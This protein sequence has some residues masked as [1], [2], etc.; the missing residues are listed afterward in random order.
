M[1]ADVVDHDTKQTIHSLSIVGYGGWWLLKPGDTHFRFCALPIT[2]PL[3]ADKQKEAKQNAV[4]IEPSEQ[5]TI[6]QKHSNT[7]NLKRQPPQTN[8]A[9]SNQ[10]ITSPV[11]TKSNPCSSSTATKKTSAAT[12]NTSN[13]KT[14]AGNTSK[15]NTMHQQ[16]SSSDDSALIILPSE[17][18]GAS[19]K[20]VG[21]LRP[22]SK[23]SGR[24]KRRSVRLRNQRQQEQLVEDIASDET[25]PKLYEEPFAKK[26][27][28]LFLNAPTGKQRDLWPELEEFGYTQ[29]GK[30]I[31]IMDWSKLFVDTSNVPKM[32]IYSKTTDCAEFL[33]SM[34]DC[35]LDLLAFFLNEDTKL[36]PNG[37]LPKVGVW[38][39]EYVQDA[40]AK[41]KTIDSEGNTA[42]KRAAWIRAKVFDIRHY[43]AET[44]QI[45]SVMFASVYQKLHKCNLLYYWDRD[46]QRM[47]TISEHKLSTGSTP[48]TLRK[49][50]E[51]YK[52][53]PKSLNCN[54][55]TL[56]QDSAKGTKAQSSPVRQKAQSDRSSEGSEA[57][58][59]D[60]D[61]E[62]QI[63]TTSTT[64]TRS[65]RK[66]NGPKS[67]R[68]RSAN[69]KQNTASS[70]SKTSSSSSSESED[71]STSS[72]DGNNVPN[73]KKSP[74]YNAKTADFLGSSQKLNSQQTESNKESSEESV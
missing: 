42:F 18:V 33:E 6:P 14:S 45:K 16:S 74:G 67:F 24:S 11:A 66:V 1:S 15:T 59:E 13:R 58:N 28:F 36:Q 60:S 63:A 37:K 48:K 72:E 27:V 43:F 26:T 62:K 23:D 39:A 4:K 44:L 68:K 10:A 8:A 46:Q 51:A 53:Y 20:R 64:T 12:K 69:R 30:D 57:D 47:E 19:R 35:N 21:A 3:P 55:C 49:M 65:R 2:K 7:D 25:E 52:K 34:D 50:H 61:Q 41:A 29:C 5:F 70:V 38:S 73:K 56:Y 17:P 40:L 22:S 9:K 31:S 71:F 54:Y 32:V